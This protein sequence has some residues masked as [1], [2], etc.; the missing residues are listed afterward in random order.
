[1]KEILEMKRVHDRSVKR[2]QEKLRKEQEMQ[3]KS[4]V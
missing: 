4:K 2:R 3:E 1:M